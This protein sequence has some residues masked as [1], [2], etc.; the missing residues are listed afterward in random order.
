MSPEMS[1][2]G[3][4]QGLFLCL[5]AGPADLSGFTSGTQTVPVAPGP[6]LAGLAE[7]VAGGDGA[8]LAGVPEDA[9]YA[10]IGAG[11]RMSSW[12]TWL[13]L[14]AM[15]ELAVRHPEPPPRPAPRR[16]ATQ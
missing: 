4:A 1:A 16:P 11:R 7:A 13:E 9:L 6:L 15:R 2:E 10:V 3:S 14:A 8:A 12:A 5:P